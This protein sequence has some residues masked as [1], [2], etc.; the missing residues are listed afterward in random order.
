M[1]LAN[2]ETLVAACFI[3]F[4]LFTSY[5]VNPLLG[6]SGHRAGAFV[7]NWAI[8]MVLL[9]P[10]VDRAKNQGMLEVDLDPCDLRAPVPVSGADAA[11]LRR[12]LYRPMLS[13]PSASR[14][15]ARSTGS[16]ASSPSSRP[17]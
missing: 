2:G 8:Y 3:A 11:R 7:I 13:S 10:L 12:G 15:S 5:A 4:W 1:N 16:T 9:R 6:L 14:F 17:A